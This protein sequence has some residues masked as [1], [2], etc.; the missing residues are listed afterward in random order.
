M[1]AKPRLKPRISPQP[2]PGWPTMR[3]PLDAFFEAVQVN[4]DHQIIRRNRLNLLAEMRKLCLGVADLT[5][6]KG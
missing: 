4:T 3:A 2:W 1:I 6:I 5:R